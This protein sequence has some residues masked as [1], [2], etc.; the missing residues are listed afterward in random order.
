MVFLSA[1][2]CNK[3][4][5]SGQFHPDSTVPLGNSGEI[6]SDAKR[7][8]EHGN[9]TP[10]TFRVLAKVTAIDKTNGTMT[11]KHEKME[12]FMDAMEM[13][14]NVSATSLFE[15]VRVGTEGHFTIRVVNDEGTIVA[16]HIHNK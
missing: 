14:Y 10:K 1:V 16:I 2:G 9:T 4:E 8:G 6:K 13:Q 5:K 7:G 11:I 12:G 3:N 15:G